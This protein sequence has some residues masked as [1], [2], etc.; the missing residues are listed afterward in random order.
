MAWPRGEAAACKAVHTGAIEL[1]VEQMQTVVV[2]F[3]WSLVVAVALTMAFK[4]RRMEMDAV[5]DAGLEP[6]TSSV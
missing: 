3:A 6:T 2:A 4:P 1:I 5:G